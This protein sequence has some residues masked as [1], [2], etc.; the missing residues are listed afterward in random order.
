MPGERIGGICRDGT[1][2]TA[3]GRGAGS[4]HGGIAQWVH[5]DSGKT[6]SSNYVSYNGGHC[7]SN[8]YGFLSSNLNKKLV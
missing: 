8:S 5:A 7:A 6:S 2:T 4:H 3:T 1:Y